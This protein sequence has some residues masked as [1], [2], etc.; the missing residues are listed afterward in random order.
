MAWLA[1][2]SAAAIALA[3]AASP[4]A[5]L[6]EGAAISDCRGYEQTGGA[7]IA[8]SAEARGGSL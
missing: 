4:I 7:M 2:L 5:Y 3:R 1:V 6:I 8:E